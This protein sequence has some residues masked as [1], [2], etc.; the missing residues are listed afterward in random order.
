MIDSLGLQDVVRLLGYRTDLE[1]VTPAVDLVVSCSLREGMPLNI[2]EAMLCKKPVVASHNRGHDELVE[3]G[4]TG[5]LRDP[6][7]SEG[8]ADGIYRISYD[9]LMQSTFGL[10][11][12]DRAIP[13][14]VYEVKQELGRIILGIY[15]RQL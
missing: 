15:D 3:D 8:F 11:A 14:S 6:E 2:I 9:Q 1:K 12:Y 13:Y 10:S 5:F 7:D 4:R